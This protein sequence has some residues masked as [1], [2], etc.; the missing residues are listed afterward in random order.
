MMFE[1]HLGLFGIQ[2]I[3]FAA[4]SFS[5][6]HCVTH[7][8]AFGFGSGTLLEIGA[9]GSAFWIGKHASCVFCTL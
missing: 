2:R 5:C 9:C 3:A 4:Y 1:S 8:C 6:F 7:S